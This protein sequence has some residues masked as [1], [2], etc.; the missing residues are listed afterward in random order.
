MADASHKK[1]GISRAVV[2]ATA[3]IFIGDGRGEQVKIR[4]EERA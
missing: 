3:I 1:P 2:I 4:K